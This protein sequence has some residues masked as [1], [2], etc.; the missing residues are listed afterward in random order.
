MKTAKKSSIR[1]ASS[2][3]ALGL[4]LAKGAAWAD[5]PDQ[6]QPPPD[7]YTFQPP[8]AGGIY[9]DTVFGTSIKRISNARQTPNVAD[10]GNLLFVTHEY[11]TM[12]P[13]NRDNTRLL[14]QHQSYYAL[15]DGEGNFI[16]DLEQVGTY[17]EPRWS[18]VDR[19]VLY[20]LYGN[21]LRQLNAVTGATLVVRTF[22][23]YSSVSGGGE[24][25]TCF[26]GDH[27][28]LAGDGRYIFVYELSTG[29]KGPVL[30]AAGRG[31]DSLY[32]TP[33]D[34]VTV[35]WFERGTGRYTGIELFDRNMNF[36][37]QVA[38]AG[39][40]MDVTRDLNG[41]EVLVW[42]NAADSAAICVNGVV[43]VR[44]SDGQ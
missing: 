34:N 16:K 22:Q 26:D 42:S 25:D 28:A 43:K 4:T 32:V 31:F 41:D 24:S 1:R 18:R 40:H 19:E 29:H 2:W 36:L 37:R 17:M 21:Q 20:Y 5:P 33:D 7:Y 27:L 6:V 39:G 10:T 30:D 9:V 23:E 8:S 11:S 14:I 44:L 38:Q 12:S 3:L 13:F 15:Y 35:T